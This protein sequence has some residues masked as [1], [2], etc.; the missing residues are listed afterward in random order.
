MNAFCVFQPLSAI[1]QMA[2]NDNF[3]IVLLMVYIPLYVLTNSVDLA[4]ADLSLSNIGF[5]KIFM[6]FHCC[7]CNLNLFYVI[8]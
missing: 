6:V 7:I 5:F 1:K 4:M 3:I 2:M 8:K